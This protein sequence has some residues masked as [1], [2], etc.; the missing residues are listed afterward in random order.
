MISGVAL[1]IVGSEVLNGYILDTNT[2]EFCQKL[3]RLGIEV[4]EARTS[5][6]DKMQILKNWKELKE[7]NYLIINS[8]GLGPTDDDLTIDLLCEFLKVEPVNDPYAEKKARVFFKKRNFVNMSE[9]QKQ[10]LWE[11]AMRQVRIPAGSKSLRNM[12]GIAPG[13]YVE[14]IPMIALPGFPIEIESIWP[15]AEKI[16]KKYATGKASTIE[17]P[18]WG[19]GESS[20]FAQVEIDDS[21]QVGVHAL[22]L[23]CRL[24]LKSEDQKKLSDTRIMLEEKFRGTTVENPLVSFVEFLGSAGL[25]LSTVESCTGGLAGKLITDIPGVSSVFKGGCITYSNES[26]VKM[27]NVKQSSLDEYGAVS[28]QVASEMARGGLVE[29]ETD[30][31]ISFTGVAG[32]GGGSKEK[33]VGLVYVGLASRKEKEVWVGC[34]SYPMGRTRFREATVSTAFLALYQKE[35]H[36]KNSETWL[37]S[38]L[39]RNFTSFN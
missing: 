37:N 7:Q 30:F 21:V 33:P 27:V 24:F 19:I 35:V 14:E 2:R 25:T 1:S 5:R 31:C 22:A 9:Q 15:E 36:Y 20:L 3:H 16:L 32:P 8:G 28:G 10:K 12:T 13:V 38:N 4:K 11:R 6:D 17:V 23:G 26:K 29:F 39:G 34:F 18:V